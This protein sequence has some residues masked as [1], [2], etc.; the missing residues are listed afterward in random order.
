MNQNGRFCVVS[1]PVN[2]PL[3][4]PVDDL[5]KNSMGYALTVLVK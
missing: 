4:L 3:K 2:D 1:L 5:P